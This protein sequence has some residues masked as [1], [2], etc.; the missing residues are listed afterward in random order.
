M[1]AQ[2][3][4]PCLPFLRYWLSWLLNRGHQLGDAHRRATKQLTRSRTCRKGCNIMASFGNVFSWGAITEGKLE[5]VESLRG[6]TVARLA[7]SGNT[8]AALD[9]SHNVVWLSPVPVCV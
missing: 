5:E 2:L 7:T 1:F 8:A 4:V 3:G 9:A 6:K